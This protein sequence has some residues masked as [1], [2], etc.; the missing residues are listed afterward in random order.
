MS[1]AVNPTFLSGEDRGETW[2]GRGETWEARGETWE[3]K[4][5]TWQRITKVQRKKENDGKT[6]FIK[7]CLRSVV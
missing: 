6:C 4:G 3:N 1:N 5:E 2:E 7:V